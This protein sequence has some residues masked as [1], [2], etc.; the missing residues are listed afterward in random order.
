ML[1]LVHHI[2]SVIIG[3]SPCWFVVFLIFIL[4]CHHYWCYYWFIMLLMLCQFVALLVLLLVHHI[5]NV[6]CYALMYSPEPFPPL[7][8][9]LSFCD[10]SHYFPLHVFW[11]DITFITIAIYWV[12]IVSDVNV[13]CIVIVGLLCWMCHGEVLPHPLPCAS[14]GTPLW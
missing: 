6:T 4:F 9:L 3:S 5:V 10:I 1:L 2:T 13:H 12:S 8:L 14:G 7:L 11:W